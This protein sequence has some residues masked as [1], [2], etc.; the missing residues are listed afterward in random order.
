LVIIPFTAAEQGE[1]AASGEAWV[2]D[3]ADW[4]A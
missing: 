4:A 2:L 3:A 1:A